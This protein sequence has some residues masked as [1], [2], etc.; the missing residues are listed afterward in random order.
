MFITRMLRALLALLSIVCFAPSLSAAETPILMEQVILTSSS[1]SLARVWNRH[2][3]A[4][5][6][7]HPWKE[8]WEMNCVRTGIPCTEDAWRTQVQPGTVVYLPA[9]TI[10]VLATTVGA[11]PE[12][13]AL[14]PSAT[15][16][17][18]SFAP[19]APLVIAEQ[20]ATS[21]QLLVEVSKVSALEKTS[22]HTEGL[23]TLL[24]TLA[25]VSLVTLVFV[26]RRRKVTGDDALAMRNRISDLEE[27]LATMTRER[28][29]LRA[30][31]APKPTVE[32]SQCEVLQM[33]R[34]AE[35]STPRETSTAVAVRS[36]ELFFQ[37]EGCC[38]YAC[39]GGGVPYALDERAV[40]DTSQLKL[41]HGDRFY[42]DVS[43]DYY[44]V[45]VL[46][47]VERAPPNQD[48]K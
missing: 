9:P 46:I 45:T 16:G 30:P 32:V 47:D 42:A 37:V 29:R 15:P 41:K 34:V 21:K 4:Y 20:I 39:D 36:I 18:L 31:L 38:T 11:P 25:F 28:D 3:V 19:S 26:A 23:V 43:A 33:P 2:D 6:K 35:P 17:V 5:K 1:P 48:T 14:V 44:V 12:A 7:A 13:I 10:V 27:D 40:K 24:G 22:K 8:V